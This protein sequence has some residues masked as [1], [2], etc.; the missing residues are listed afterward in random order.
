[1]DVQAELVKA[2]SASRAFRDLCLDRLMDRQTADERARGDSLERN[3]RGFSRQHAALMSARA[4]LSDDTLEDICVAYTTQ[5]E[6]MIDAGELQVPPP[7]G[8]PSASASDRS[9]RSDESSD[10]AS[11]EASD[12]VHINSV[13]AWSRGRLLCASHAFRRRIVQ[14]ARDVSA[15]D[16]S[17]PYWEPEEVRARLL[18]HIGW[19]GPVPSQEEV[20]RVLFAALPPLRLDAELQGSYVRLLWTDGRWLPALVLSVHA[21]PGGIPRVRV[22]FVEVRSAVRPRSSRCAVA[23]RLTARAVRQE[24]DEDERAGT[25]TGPDAAFM[26][27]ITRARSGRASGKRR[28]PVVDESE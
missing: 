1:M 8:S 10:E 2:I 5:L 9:D 16:R 25:I 18:D 3:G 12:D 28:R 27:C 19:Q 20:D 24:E 21:P 11:D 13:G 22:E 23:A 4:T 6:E 15:A 17:R 14:L 26:Y 7:A